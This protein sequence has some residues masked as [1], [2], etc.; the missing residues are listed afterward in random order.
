M[1]SG[2]LLVVLPQ[3]IEGLGTDG[4]NRCSGRWLVVA[5]TCTSST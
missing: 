5:L 1:N 2:A 3:L 4:R